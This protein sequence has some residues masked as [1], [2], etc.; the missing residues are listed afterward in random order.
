MREKKKKKRNEKH[1]IQIV[2][3]NF[4]YIG[5]RY[6]AQAGPELKILPRCWAL[7]AHT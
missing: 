2:A 3:L 5:S 4:F 1:N 6:V 7:V